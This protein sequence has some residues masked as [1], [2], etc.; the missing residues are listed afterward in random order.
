MAANTEIEEDI[1]TDEMIGT[2][3]PMM[4]TASFR[5]RLRGRSFALTGRILRINRLSKKRNDNIP[6]DM[7]QQSAIIQQMCHQIQV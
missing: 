3:R 4:R 6:V 1:Q 2:E 5:R 7:T